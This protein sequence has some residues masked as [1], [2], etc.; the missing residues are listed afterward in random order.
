M[1]TV[2]N[3][4]SLAATGSTNSHKPSISSP[5]R[6]HA[7][8][9]P[10]DPICA[11]LYAETMPSPTPSVTASAMATKCPIRFLDHHSPE[12]VAKY[13]ETHKHEIP[14]SHEI[15]VKRYQRNEEDIIKLD[16]KYGNLVSMIQGLGQKHQSMLP[17]KEEEEA[18]DVERSSNER[19]QN[20]AK[21]ISVDGTDHEE[22][23]S[24][25]N[26]DD[27]SSRFDR[28]LKEVRVGES[29]SRPW[30]I[31]VPVLERPMEQRAASP[32]PAPV[33]KTT[34]PSNMTTP[35]GKCPFG[36]GG[37][38]GPTEEK[39][40]PGTFAAETTPRP[41]TYSFSDRKPA[42]SFDFKPDDDSK[43]DEDHRQSE[44]FDGGPPKQPAFI[45]APDFT[46]TGNSQVPQMIFTGPVFVGYS[47]E[48]A[49][50]FL[51][52]YQQRQ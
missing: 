40:S 28:P 49:M 4:A 3:D 44:S 45:P 17:T 14:R 43:Q 6:E 2:L 41:N 51:Q 11:A 20:W 27:R 7:V 10:S 37:P 34:D 8:H 25:Q 1:P 52:Q 39:P 18:V 23:A 29:P 13:F 26:E 24:V 33:P 19:V 5:L 15:C 36:H 48:Q 16:A 50:A 32:P 21:G 12:E 30:G 31:S 38:K 9:D 42:V 47:F 22:T 35:S 46:R